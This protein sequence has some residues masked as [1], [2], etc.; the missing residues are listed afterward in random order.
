MAAEA[1]KKREEAEIKAE[2][3]AERQKFEML[4]SGQCSAQ[5][6]QEEVDQL[7][8]KPDVDVGGEGNNALVR[9]DS[10]PKTIESSE[11]KGADVGPSSNKFSSGVGHVEG[12]HVSQ[13]NEFPEDTAKTIPVES[14][15]IQ[16][17]RE[18]LFSDTSETGTKIDSDNDKSPTKTV[19]TNN[20]SPAS[21]G[22]ESLNLPSAADGE[23]WRQQRRSSCASSTGASED[24]YDFRSRSPIPLLKLSGDG[25]GPLHLEV[26][27]PDLSI[28]EGHLPSPLP[29]PL[30]TPVATPRRRPT[31]VGIGGLAVGEGDESGSNQNLVDVIEVLRH[32]M[33]AGKDGNAVPERPHRRRNSR[34]SVTDLGDMEGVNT[35]EDVEDFNNRLVF[36]LP[37]RR[38]SS[39][40]PFHTSSRRSSRDD[41]DS[42]TNKQNSK[43]CE[44]GGADSDEGIGLADEDIFVKSVYHASSSQ[45]PPPNASSMLRISL[46]SGDSHEP[47]VEHVPKPGPLPP[48]IVTVDP[49]DLCE[50]GSE[51]MTEAEPSV[52]R[53]PQQQTQWLGVAP[54]EDMESPRSIASRSELSA[55]NTSLTSPRTDDGGSEDD[56]VDLLLTKRSDLSSARRPLSSRTLTSARSCPSEYELDADSVICSINDDAFSVSSNQRHVKYAIDD[57]NIAGFE[58]VKTRSISPSMKSERLTPTKASI[59]SK[60][61]Q[62]A[63]IPCKTIELKELDLKCPVTADQFSNRKRFGM[64]PRDVSKFL[65]LGKSPAYADST[66]GAN[67]PRSE[68]QMTPRAAAT[69]RKLSPTLRLSSQEGSD[70]GIRRQRPQT[71]ITQRER[72]ILQSRRISL[73]EDELL[74]LYDRHRNFDSPNSLD[75]GGGSSAIEITASNPIKRHAEGDTMAQVKRMERRILKRS[76]T[77]FDLF[78]VQEGSTAVDDTPASDKSFKQLAASASLLRREQTAPRLLSAGSPKPSQSDEEKDPS[79]RRCTR[80]SDANENRASF[81]RSVVPLTR[82][83]MAYQNVR[84]RRQSREFNSLSRE[85]ERSG[86]SLYRA[87]KSKDPIS[88]YALDLSSPKTPKSGKRKHHHNSYKKHSGRR[89]S[90]RSAVFSRKRIEAEEE[91]A[92]FP[93]G[94]HDVPT[95]VGDL[96]DP[97]VIPDEVIFEKYRPNTTGGYR[98]R[99]RNGQ[100]PPQSSILTLELPRD[101][102]H[103]PK[104]KSVSL[105]SKLPIK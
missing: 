18:T 19:K 5:E 43:T 51:N 103:T 25:A 64:I 55:I 58:D 63:S 52:S 36:K 97:D 88:P 75:K 12:V 71:A 84:K 92:D 61:F 57:K 47:W 70:I 87:S 96:S 80:S 34:H 65:V 93:P 10:P 20:N 41:S 9:D 83:V 3:E 24:D 72:D 67:T 77:S 105:L 21:L 35:V 94:G 100:R 28:V 17:K 102:C 7:P 49:L 95:L 1:K 81:S 85:L 50:N 46:P 99:H 56:N 74:P 22:V 78:P 68:Q 66:V 73:M 62:K 76:Q 11:V 48:P 40:V 2:E 38:R 8:E 86:K 42:F 104:V 4:K 79:P 16:E 26:P 91:L 14:P 29:T 69:S 15:E 54:V 6:S 98:H 59:N 32:Q 23:S 44:A 82:V 101:A 60:N 33:L 45:A 27:P 89:S 13:T 53:L 37:P 39:T 90:T 31:I 30:E